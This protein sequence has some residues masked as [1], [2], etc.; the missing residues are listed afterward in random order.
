[1][2][3]RELTQMNPATAFGPGPGATPVTKGIP[4]S[5]DVVKYKGRKVTAQ[6]DKARIQASGGKAP[7][8]L[9]VP[10]KPKKVNARND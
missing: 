3:K 6:P 10:P 8:P 7:I 1:M 5:P 4:P 9:M 2:N